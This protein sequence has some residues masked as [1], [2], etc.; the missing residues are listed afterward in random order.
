MSV[1]AARYNPLEKEGRDA[2][3]RGEPERFQYRAEGGAYL[4]LKGLPLEPLREIDEEK[5]A[6][7]CRIVRALG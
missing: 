5:I 6:S 4:N 2:L 3:A 1:A 7:L